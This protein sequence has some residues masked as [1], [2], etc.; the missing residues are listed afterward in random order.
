MSPE[1]RDHYREKENIK[2]RAASRT[3]AWKAIGGSSDPILPTVTQETVASLPKAVRT[4]RVVKSE[5]PSS[6]LSGLGKVKRVNP[7]AEIVKKI[8]HERGLSM[9]QAS[10]V[11]KAENLWSKGSS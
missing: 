7:R 2:K 3:K 9:C 11:V 6:T 8:M 1:L 10:K 5:L 4:R